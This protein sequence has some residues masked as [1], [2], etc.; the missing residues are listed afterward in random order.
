MDTFGK[1]SALAR[2]QIGNAGAVDPLKYVAKLVKIM[3]VARRAVAFDKVIVRK[4][5][6]YPETPLSSGNRFRRISAARPR[7][8]VSDGKSSTLTIETQRG[9]ASGAILNICLFPLRS[10]ASP[11][12][13]CLCPSPK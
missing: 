1:I 9:L 12:A 8:A 2:T 6:G 5:Q 4:L 13:D 7:N 11:A 10:G 3:P